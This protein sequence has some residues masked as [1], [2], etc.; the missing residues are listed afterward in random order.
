MKIRLFVLTCESKKHVSLD[1]TN[2]E[3]YLNLELLMYSPVLFTTGTV[4]HIVSSLF[5][6]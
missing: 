3:N 2:T 6:R 5:L 1:E 4:L